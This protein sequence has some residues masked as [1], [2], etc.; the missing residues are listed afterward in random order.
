MSCPEYKLM[1]DL[2]S[3]VDAADEEHSDSNLINEWIDQLV[4][5]G[6]VTYDEGVIQ[7]KGETYD[8]CYEFLD[9]LEDEPELAESY[10]QVLAEWL[11]DFEDYMN[12]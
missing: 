10:C 9:G 5:E 6:V 11:A 7:Y 4:F 3:Q 1:L 8:G 2:R 12:E